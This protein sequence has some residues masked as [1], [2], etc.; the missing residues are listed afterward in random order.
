MKSELLDLGTFGAKLVLCIR[1]AHRAGGEAVTYA[2]LAREL[3]VTT[4]WAK[5]AAHKAERAGMV[6]ITDAHGRGIK[7]QLSLTPKG[8]SA[9]AD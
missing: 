9:C 6:K 3:G 8:H 7:A 4:K 1:N 5:R 2:W